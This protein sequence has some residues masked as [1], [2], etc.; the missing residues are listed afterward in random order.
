MN[1]LIIYVDENPINSTELNQYMVQYHR[2]LPEDYQ[3]FLINFNGGAIYHP[4][5]RKYFFFNINRFFSLGDLILQEKTNCR[6]NDWDFM[7]ED[8]QLREQLN[9]KELLPIANC[10]QGTIMLSLRQEDIGAIYYSHYTGGEGVRKSP[11]KSFE[12][13]LSCF[14]INENEKAP[15]REEYYHADRKLFES[16][17][18]ITQEDANLGLERF[19]QVYSKFNDPNFKE[20]PPFNTSLLQKYVFWKP[21]FNFLIEQGAQ[22]E[23]T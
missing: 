19:K 10:D 14:S 11:F 9:Y 17:F 3:Q 22:P 13:F 12:E 16:N 6:F 21:I 5:K 7:S 23:T 4:E 8:E 2:Q 20:K 1:K 15:H 18:F